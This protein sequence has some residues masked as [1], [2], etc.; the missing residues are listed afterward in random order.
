MVLKIFR[1]LMILILILLPGWA[2]GMGESNTWT[3]CGEG[4]DFTSIQA[5]IDAA[6]PGDAV[7]VDPETAIEFGRYVENIVIDKSIILEGQGDLEGELPPVIRAKDGNR[8]VIRVE[9]QVKG[10]IIRGFEIS[11]GVAGVSVGDGAQVT[12]KANSIVENEAGITIGGARTIIQDNF[13][14]RNRGMGIRI[15]AEAVS[16]EIIH[17][18]ILENGS[19]SGGVG[20]EAFMSGKSSSLAILDNSISRTIRGN[21]IWILTEGSVELGGNVIAGNE[22]DGI[23]ASFGLVKIVNNVVVSNFGYGME[24]FGEEVEIIGNI[25]AGNNMDGVV[26]ESTPDFVT[27]FFVEENQIRLNRRGIVLFLSSCFEDYDDY[28]GAYIP[29]GLVADPFN[30]EISGSDNII[31]KNYKGNLCPEDYPWPEGFV[32]ED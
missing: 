12:I 22:E 21:G 14:F 30:G 6:S 24:V 26:L 1:T 5:A 18:V 15:G 29:S 3:V 13:I 2:I 8:P 27:R 9:S 20:I 28:E 4:C 17:N 11:G 23:I 7:I 16:I 19:S 10:V 31:E 32:R 25:I